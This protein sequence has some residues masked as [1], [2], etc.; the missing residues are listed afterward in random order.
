MRIL[1]TKR[2]TKAEEHGRHGDTVHHGRMHLA[3]EKREEGRKLADKFHK[4][5]R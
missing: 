1:I 3:R 2:C 5:I 4:P